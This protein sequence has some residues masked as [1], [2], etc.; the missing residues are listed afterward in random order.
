MRRFFLFF[1]FFDP[2]VEIREDA[3]AAQVRTLPPQHPL[4]MAGGMGLVD[5]SGGMVGMAQQPG[6]PV[7]PDP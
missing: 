3:A 6:L 7:N 5:G 1:F 2:R 4:G